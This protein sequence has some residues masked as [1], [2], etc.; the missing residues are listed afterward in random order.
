MRRPPRKTAER[1]A[2]V[3]ARAGL[4]S[5]R[6][7]EAW[8]AAGR[9]RST[10]RRSP[11]PRST[12]ATTDKIVVDGKPLPQRERTRLFLYHKPRGLVTTIADPRRPPDH[13]RRAAEGP[14]AR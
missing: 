13:L 3:I 10:A 8:I 11:R 2:K 5:R 6:E 1:I 12:C 4:C 14:A 7:A 9:V